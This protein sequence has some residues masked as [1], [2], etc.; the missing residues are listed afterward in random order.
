MVT[1]EKTWERIMI[2]LTA[3]VVVVSRDW[4]DEIYGQEERVEMR[5]TRTLVAYPCR[6]YSLRNSKTTGLFQQE[7]PVSIHD[8]SSQVG[9][10]HIG[11]YNDD[12][13]LDGEIPPIDWEERRNRRKG[14]YRNITATE[15]AQE[16]DSSN[17]RGPRWR[18]GNLR[19]LKQERT[20]VS[21]RKCTLKDLQHIDPLDYLAK[22]C[23][24]K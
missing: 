2:P 7:E 8:L 21:A 16:D 15:G 3:K 22:Y 9:S 1:T 17:G 6:T 11:E 19:K 13:V 10:S 14:R 4:K 23:I 18:R 5:T 24:I 20:D 12:F